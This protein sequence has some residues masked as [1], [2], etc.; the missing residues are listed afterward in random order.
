MNR[1]VQWVRQGYSLRDAP[2]STMCHMDH[3]GIVKIRH[4]NTV[5]HPATLNANDELNVAE[6]IKA[7]S[8]WNMHLSKLEV[9]I[10]Q[11]YPDK[12]GQGN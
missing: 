5:G 9:R 11:S 8:S 4:N 10:V 7:L 2:G 1:S 12:S 3:F 6:T